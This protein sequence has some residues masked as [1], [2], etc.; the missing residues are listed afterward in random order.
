MSINPQKAADASVAAPL[1]A[2]LRRQLEAPALEYA[3]PPMT[4]GQGG[5][6]RIMAFSLTDPAAQSSW[7]NVPLVCRIELD[8]A[9][10]MGE[11]RRTAALHRLLSDQGFPAPQILVVGDQTDDMRAPFIVMERLSGESVE[12]RVEQFTFLWAG[13]MILAAVFDLTL[14]L[15]L[16]LFGSGVLCIVLLAALTAR[17]LLKLHAIP[18]ATFINQPDL[19]ARAIEFHSGKTTKLDELNYI[20]RESSATE[21][22][23]G[24]AWLY[25]HV[26]DDH[27]DGVLCHGD[28]HGGNVIIDSRGIS[29]VLDWPRAVIAAREFDLAWT[30]LMHAFIPDP[31]PHTPAAISRWI[32]PA[33][34]TIHMT[35]IWIYL[36]I[37][38]LWYRLAV[39]LDANKYRFFTAYHALYM[40]AVGSLAVGGDVASGSIPQRRLRHYFKR[41]TGIDIADSK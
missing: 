27:G 11:L 15:W 18:T 37:Q 24:L 16:A 6:A 38:E 31:N 32:E 13:I 23:P 33:Y 29:G 36:R 12:S 28:F 34:W 2:T 17:L 35:L 10:D 8:P 40:L 5:E 25:Q 22:E 1:L 4:I 26:P 7:G 21:L 9:S 30:L 39:P 41:A 19:N 20:I 3:E 14:P